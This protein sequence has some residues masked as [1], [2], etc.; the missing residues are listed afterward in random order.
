MWIRTTESYNKVDIICTYLTTVVSKC[1]VRGYVWTLDVIVEGAVL[2][3]VLSKEAERVVVPKVFKLD[4][5][6]LPVFVH[7]SFHELINEIVICLGAVSLLV[8]PHVKRILKE[9]LTGGQG[10][11]WEAKV[12]TVIIFLFSHTCNKQKEKNKTKNQHLAFLPRYPS[13]HR[14]PQGDISQVWCQH[15][16]CTGKVSQQVFPFHK[17]PG[18]LIPRY[19]LHQLLLL[20]T[21]RRDGGSTLVGKLKIKI[22]HIYKQ[23]SYLYDIFLDFFSNVISEKVLL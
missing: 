15:R 6:V 12:N 14:S 16:Q 3:P 13:Q 21:Q 19:A 10:Q 20:P 9:S 1:C 8:Q 11:P 22:W 23:L 2:L 5:R 4:Q 18:P 7:D 17:H